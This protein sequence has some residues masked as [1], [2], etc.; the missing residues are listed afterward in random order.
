[1]MATTAR[2]MDS[3]QKNEA[4]C[5]SASH[6]VKNGY[7]QNTFVL[8]FS[9]LKVLLNSGNMNP[10]PPNSSPNPPPRKRCDKK[11]RGTEFIMFKL[12]FS[13][14]ITCPTSQSM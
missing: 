1:M 10:L 11:A 3:N 8:D 12:K 4:V 5:I 9:K 14:S 7:H 13:S 6:C 2:V